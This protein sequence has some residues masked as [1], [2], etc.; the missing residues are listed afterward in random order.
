[1]RPVWRKRPHLLSLFACGALT[2]AA[3]VGTAM[4]LPSGPRGFDA[5]PTIGVAPV[6]FAEPWVATPLPIHIT[7]QRIA[8][9]GFIQIDGLPS[10]AS[11]SEGHAIRPGSWM[12]P[13]AKLATLKIVSP[14]T[15]DAQ[16]RL[17]VTLLSQQGVVLSEARPLLAVMRPELLAP[18]P[19]VLPPLPAQ[20]PDGLPPKAVEEPSAA[21]IWPGVRHEARTLVRRGD[22]SLARGSV[23]AARQT[24][25]Y[26]ADEMRWPT[27]ALALAATYDPHELAYLAPLV[28][29]DPD[30]ARIW[31]E[32]ARALTDARI[33]FHLRRLGAP[34][35]TPAETLR[36][37]APQPAPL[38]VWFV[39][40]EAKTIVSWG[41]EALSRGSVAAARQI[42]EY[43]AVVMRWPAAALA[44][45]ATYD[46]DE[47]AHI[48][49]PFAPEPERARA[50]Y[51][52]SREMMH[53]RIDFH[54]QRLGAPKLSRLTRP[55]RIASC[56]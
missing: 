45:A 16:P 37:M 19:A 36:P 54:L 33:E 35:D 2:G 46:K 25:E 39:A 10:L 55:E 32:Q 22:D 5:R 31:Y 42:Y 3:I 27:A 7:P 24:Y 49:Y 26:V 30:K 6:V 53:A 43:A 18:Q 23:G 28:V 12:V 51:E 8:G 50:W 52:R 13:V 14:G 56:G 9:G 48:A 29:P 17:V 40:M 41:D 20:C 34:A 11:L 21:W 4:L 38:W 1:L 44:L 15:E 47:L